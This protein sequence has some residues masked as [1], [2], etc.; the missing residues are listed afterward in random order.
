MNA[1]FPLCPEM[2]LGPKNI[3]G[4]ENQGCQLGTPAIALGSKAPLIGFQLPARPHN[5]ILWLKPG[6]IANYHRRDV[7]CRILGYYPA[8]SLLVTVTASERVTEEG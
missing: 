2:G 8:C 6:N 7:R 4:V 5:D 3:R 1:A